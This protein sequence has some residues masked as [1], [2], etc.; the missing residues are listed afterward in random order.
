MFQATKDLSSAI[1]KSKTAKV[2]GWTE[3]FLKS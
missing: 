3:N 1:N 2:H